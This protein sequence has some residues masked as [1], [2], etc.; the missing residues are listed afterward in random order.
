MSSLLEPMDTIE[1]LVMAVFF[2][3]VLIFAD[4]LQD[5]IDRKKAENDRRIR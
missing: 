2:I 4:V 3:A 5:H 1:V